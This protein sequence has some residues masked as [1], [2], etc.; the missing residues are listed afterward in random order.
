MDS[1]LLAQAVD[2][3]SAP[4]NKNLHA[5]H[6]MTVIRH[7]HIAADVCFH[8]FQPGFRHVIASAAKVFT[9]TLIGIAIDK[10]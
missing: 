10:G 4:V 9:T 6:N 5:V 2:R 1:A 3:F 8:P 7:G